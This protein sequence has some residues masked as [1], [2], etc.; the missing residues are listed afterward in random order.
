M[1]R[2]Y[3]KS[4]QINEHEYPQSFEYFISN[5]TLLFINQK[6]KSAMLEK[7]MCWLRQL[8]LDEFPLA[9]LLDAVSS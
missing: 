3:R 1:Q 5:C 2:V 8:C 6:W 7:K 9:N 4:Y